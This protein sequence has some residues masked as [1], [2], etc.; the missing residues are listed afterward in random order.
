[1]SYSS[2]GFM[3][4]LSIVLV[5][6][7]VVP[8]S[9]GCS[10]DDSTA[11]IE[12]ETVATPLFD[13]SSGAYSSIQ[14]VTIT[15][16][17]ADASVYYTTDGA[18]PD[19]SSALFA[20]GDSI[21]VAATTA[22]K[23]RA[24]KE[25]M[26]PSAIADAEYF[27]DLPDVAAPY[28]EPEGG[29]YDAPLDA[30]IHCATAD[31]RI[32]YTT[33]ESD[34]DTNSTEFIF[35]TVIPV[36]ATTTLRARAYKE[37]M[38]PSEIVGVKYALISDLVAYYPFE[39]NANDES[40]N[41]HDGTVYGAA[42]VTDRFGSPAAAYQFDGTDD[43]IELSDEAAFDFS[44]FTI[45]FWTRITTL[46]VVPGPSIPGY[47]CAIS[48]AGFNLGNYTI[49]LFK[50]RRSE[51]LLYRA[52]PTPRASETGTPPAIPTSTSTSITT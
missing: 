46:P 13:P 17:T 6:A 50:T 41:G 3:M 47:Y 37:G 43:Y 14:Y 21:E 4:R 45:S 29:V 22:F 35:Q 7:A 19:E 5:L 18:D 30:I 32:F 51:L 20:A 28:F 23:A 16:S 39:G 40:G 2:G 49:R 24:Y 34:P 33:D 1:M 9:F 10:S 31:A 26:N 42:S 36:A 25:G 52:T 48:K 38:D 8:F 12:K 44:E 27:I 11:G 15:C